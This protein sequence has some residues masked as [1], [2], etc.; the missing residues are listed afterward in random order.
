MK[1]NLV[2]IKNMEKEY[3][4]L[5]MEFLKDNLLKMK[6]LKVHINGK[7]EEYIKDNF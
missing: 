2:M 1:E 6:F 7:M 3:F 4:K 5:R